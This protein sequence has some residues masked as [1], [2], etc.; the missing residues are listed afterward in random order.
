MEMPCNTARAGS[1]GVVRSLVVQRVSLIVRAKS[2]NVPPMSA[3]SRIS[4]M[5][6]YHTR[7]A[8]LKINFV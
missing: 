6:L 2:V 1:D 8:E 5:G 4:T 3:A 7:I